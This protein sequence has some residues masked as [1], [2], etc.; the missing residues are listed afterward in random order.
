[1]DSSAGTVEERNKRTATENAKILHEFKDGKLDVLL[2]VRMLSE[3]TDVPNINTVFITRQTTSSILLTQMIG[4]A[5]RGKRAGG[6]ENKDT[7]NIVFFVDNWKQIINF[8]TPET[9]EKSE[10]KPLVRGPYPIDYISIKLVEELSRQLDSG[11]A[12]TNHPYLD[13]L[14]LGW[15]ET[16][17]LDRNGDETNSFTEFVVV[18]E[19]T[20][21]NFDKF[22]RSI[23]ANLSIQW[24]EDDLNEE[25]ANSESARWIKEFFE[26]EH[27][28]AQTLDL[29]LIKIARHY[30]QG[31]PK[32]IPS[33]CTFE[34]R[35]KHDLSKIAENLMQENE[36]SVQ[37]K[38]DTL[39]NDATFMWHSFYKSYDRFKTAF[40]GAR[41]RIFHLKKFGT[42]LQ[43]KTPETVIKAIEQRELTEQ[44]KEQ[45]FNR[46]K[47]TCQCCGKSKQNGRRV[48]LQ[49]D[50]IDPV[51]FGGET[52]VGNSQTLCDTCNK[53]KNV[54]AVNYK[55]FA[56]RLPMPKDRLEFFP[57]IITKHYDEILKRTINIFYHCH[58]VCDVKFDDRPR[59][60]YRYVWEIELYEGNNPEWLIKH[61]QELIDF[62]RKDLNYKDLKGILI[63]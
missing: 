16:Q 39:Y 40:D 31:K 60:K 37:E 57:Q 61:K 24:E 30:A 7:A 48:K 55:V 58:A 45:V 11:A 32:Q 50:H 2:N 44:E 26:P 5:L 25:F 59:S 14:P 4:R 12:F 10:D 53:I 6:G 52:S 38:L 27:V 13:S 3:G 9:G 41:N 54:H 51:K 28:Q 20:K 34:L 22:I 33:F 15:Y 49:V 47:Y 36:Y 21:L 43:L 46:D 1:M 8:A 35:N 63:S 17:I 19:N 42:E 56:S 29:D 18:Y 62:I 23:Q